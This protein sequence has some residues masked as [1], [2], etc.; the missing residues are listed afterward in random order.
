MRKPP[1]RKPVQGDDSYQEFWIKNGFQHRGLIN[2]APAK[3]FI[4]PGGPPFLKITFF[5]QR[6]LINTAGFIN[7][8]LALHTTHYILH[9]TLH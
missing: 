7:P 6:G 5:W 8:N 2:H 4:N 1:C 3:R 9:T